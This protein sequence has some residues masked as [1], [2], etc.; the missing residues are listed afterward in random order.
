LFDAY[1]AI[2]EAAFEMAHDHAEHERLPQASE[3]RGEAGFKV[4][5]ALGVVQV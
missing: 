5:P 1:Q 4:I 2:L 3:A